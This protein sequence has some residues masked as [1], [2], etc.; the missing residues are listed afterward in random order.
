MKH[1]EEKTEEL[2]AHLRSLGF[3]SDGLE[4]DIIRNVN[5]GLPK[6]RIS[7][8]VRFDG[9]PVAFDL[10]FS[11]GR[12]GGYKLES[13]RA[14][15]RTGMEIM[16]TLH[17]GI[18]TAALEGNMK[19]VDWH[20]YFS[21]PEQAPSPEAIQKMLEQMETLYRSPDPSIIEIHQQLAFKYW[22]RDIYETLKHPQVRHM[23]IDHAVG[24]EF[25]ENGNPHTTMDGL[26]NASLAYHIV[27]GK[28]DKLYHL[29][30]PIGLEDFADLPLYAILRGEL[31]RNRETF[32]ITCSR[33]SPD[34]LVEFS[35]PVQKSDIGFDADTIHATFNPHPEIKHG[36]YGGIDS[37]ELERMMQGINWHNRDEL[38]RFEE[39]DAAPEFFPRVY[40]VQEQVYRL[41][42]DL[43]GSEVA[44][45]L[46]LKYWINVPLFDTMIQQTAWD[47][48]E[49]RPKIKREFPIVNSAT[50]IF[51]LMRGRA[52]MDR[53]MG[54]FLKGSGLWTKLDKGCRYQEGMP[55]LKRI[56]GFTIDELES[57][58]K[59]LP[60]AREALYGI[61]DALMD[62]E[63]VDFP[64]DDGK[65]VL[66]GANPEGKTLNLYTSGMVPIPFN[67]RFDPD[68]KPGKQAVS[69]RLGK[70]IGSKRNGI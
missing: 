13:Y 16:H 55:P 70:N 26:V 37:A 41:S 12:T 44:D 11:G 28:L 14:T 33:N 69:G 3:E 45:Q 24:G 6:F 68:W 66:I 30:E 64:L 53:D 52:V 27:S 56:T 40:D 1:L 46:M 22:P 42:Q 48:L 21:N 23:E 60:I 65:T 36:V 43:A 32:E 2:I 62:G 31:S 4:K 39:E 59:M 54:E 9:D 29:L 19:Q 61:R 49:E 38:F 35:I 15:C 67:F 10:L 51:N 34:G 18:D 7:H 57:H 8:E 63:I 47:E 5:I 20:A 25:V 17:E 50:R 58:L